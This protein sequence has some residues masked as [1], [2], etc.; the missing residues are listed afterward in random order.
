MFTEKHLNFTNHAVVER[1]FFEHLHD[2]CARLIAVNRPHIRLY[3]KQSLSQGCMSKQVTPRH[4]RKSFTGGVARAGSRESHQPSLPRESDDSADSDGRVGDR[5]V[6]RREG[7]SGQREPCVQG[8]G[9]KTV[10]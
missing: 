5:H 4:C 9:N 10:G 7:R 6:Q 8:T 2:G 1:V 3:G